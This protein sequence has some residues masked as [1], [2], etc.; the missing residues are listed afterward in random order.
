M[1][2]IY[3]TCDWCDKPISYGSAAVTIN[4]NIEQMDRTDEDPDGI[5]TVIHSDMVTTLCGSCGNHLDI[6]AL[7]KILSAPINKR[8]QTTPRSGVTRK[9]RRVARN[10]SADRQHLGNSKFHANHSE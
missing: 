8:R 9:K 4:K 7:R 2:D 6:D 1:E 5:V 10:G 3:T